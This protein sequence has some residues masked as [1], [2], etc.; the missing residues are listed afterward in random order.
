MILTRRV[1]DSVASERASLSVDPLRSEPQT[2]VST[3]TATNATQSKM[4]SIPL[5]TPPRSEH[6]EGEGEA[7]EQQYRLLEISEDIARLIESAQERQRS[8]TCNGSGNGKGTGN[9]GSQSRDSKRRRTEGSFSSS[10]PHHGEDDDERECLIINGRHNDEAVLSTQDKTHAL[11]EVSQSNSLLLCAIDDRRADGGSRGGK[12]SSK[13]MTMKV[14]ISSV[15]ELSQIVPRLDRVSTL[16]RGSA[17]EGDEEEKR[18]VS[19][20][21]SCGWKRRRND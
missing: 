16:L 7:P 5:C 17:Y 2:T 20:K 21:W 1:I 14:N 9:A 11:R 10:H 6:A 4:A 8:R 12:A 18:K 13:Q 19:E 3:T 15:L